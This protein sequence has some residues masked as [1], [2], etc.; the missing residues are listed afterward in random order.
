MSTYQ[1]I[2]SKHWKH[3]SGRTAS[4]Y[5][6]LPYVGRNDGWEIVSNGWTVQNPYTG[7]VGMGHP[8]CATRELA[9]ALAERLG[10]PSH[11]SMYD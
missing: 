9:Q 2:E 10:K 11:M 8:A 5:G 7:E 3:P 1:V 6:A 4:I